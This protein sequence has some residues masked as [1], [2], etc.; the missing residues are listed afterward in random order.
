MT[1]ETFFEVLGDNA[2]VLV[3]VFG[4]IAVIGYLWAR[5]NHRAR[6]R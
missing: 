1:M 5:F 2:F 6:G 3:S 4:S